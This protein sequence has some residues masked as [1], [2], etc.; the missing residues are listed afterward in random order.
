MTQQINNEGLAIVKGDE[1]CEL[2]AYLCPAHVPTIAW[3]HTGPEVHLGLTW[4]QA[5][6]DAQLLTDL[7]VFEAGV[8]RLAPK[9]TPN[10]FSAL[11]SFAY[12]EGLTKLQNSTLL[13]NHNTGGYLAAKAQFQ[14]WVYADG[15]KLGGLVKRRAQ[16]A[17][18]YGG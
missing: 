5:R 6:A 12:N 3:G 7:A 16:E 15:V 1:G 4:T 13:R 2:A 17:A 11:V 14:L 9:T 8:A 18:L 10:Q